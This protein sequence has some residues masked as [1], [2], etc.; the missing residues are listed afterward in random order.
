MGAHAFTLN[1]SST[2]GPKNLA[3]TLNVST[4]PSAVALDAPANGA[5]DFSGPLSWIADPAASTYTVTIA[6][7]AGMTNVVETGSGITGTSFQ[8]VIANV[9][10]TTYHWQVRAENGSANQPLVKPSE[11][12]ARVA[13][14]EAMYKSAKSRKWVKV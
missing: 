1:A 2:S 13:V 14:M 12:A 9:G 6:S 3:L 8:P 10:N 4:L 11:A 5:V 7:D